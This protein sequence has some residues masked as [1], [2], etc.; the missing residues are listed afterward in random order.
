MSTVL[1]LTLD[2]Y[3]AM[4]ARGA[5]DPITD[6]HIELIYGELR[7]MCPA[8]PEHEDIIDLLNRWSAR[9][10]PENK[11]RIRVQNSIGI[12]QLDSA[13]EPD[14]AWVREKSYR[15]G[16]PRPKD[17]VLVVEVSHSSID[18]D[19]GEKL[20]LYAQAGVPE[21]WIVDI[22]K[23]SVEVFREPSR[24]EYRKHDTYGRTQSV[25]PQAYPKAVLEIATLF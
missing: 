12:P 23:Q 6:K 25:A 4:I 5:F 7:Q 1:K 20:E 22:E 17:V 24:K 18:Y 13:P 3:D 11:V 2:E 21:Y 19:L 9:S 16:R 14:L 8:G 15:A 10:T